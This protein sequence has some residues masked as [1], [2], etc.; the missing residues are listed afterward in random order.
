MNLRDFFRVSPPGRDEGIVETITRLWVNAGGAPAAGL[1]D[2]AGRLRS[3]GEGSFPCMAVG[4]G[5]LRRLLLAVCD[6][7]NV[8]FTRERQWKSRTGATAESWPGSRVSM[9]AAGF[10][11]RLAISLA[12]CLSRSGK[13]CCVPS[14]ADGPAGSSGGYLRAWTRAV[15]AQTQLG[16]L[17]YRNVP[18]WKATWQ[19][20]AGPGLPLEADLFSPA[21]GRKGAFHEEFDYQTLLDAVM[22]CPA[23]D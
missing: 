11:Y 6:Q 18:Y 5:R 21:L 12:Q 23:T 22:V 19:G 13:S 16:L 17:G 4:P 10:E 15:L 20:G 7:R 8:T 2:R 9:C 1:E 3:D 14:R